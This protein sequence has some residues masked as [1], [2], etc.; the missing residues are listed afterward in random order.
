MSHAIAL[1]DRQPIVDLVAHGCLALRCFALLVRAFAAALEAF[2][3]IALR[4]LVV[5]A[6][7]RAFPPR[8]PI[9]FRNFNTGESSM[10]EY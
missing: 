1:F 9:S 3:A 2:V 5:K 8:L 7:A 6:L 10:R 4:C